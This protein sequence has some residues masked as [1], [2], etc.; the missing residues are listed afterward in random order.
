MESRRGKPAW[1]ACHR[2][3]VRTNAFST[4]QTAVTA[5]SAGDTIRVAGGTFVEGVN[6]N[7]QLLVLGNQTGAD[8]QSGRGERLKR[9][10]P[11]RGTMA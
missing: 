8:A 6:I 7:K 1:R 5:A 11:E 10:S 3:D 9:S 2:F 4:I